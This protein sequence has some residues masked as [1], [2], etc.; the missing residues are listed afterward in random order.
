MMP[1]RSRTQE[2]ATIAGG[3]FWCLQPLFQDLRGVEKVE[4]GYS[5]GHLANPSYEAVC[6]DTTGHAEAVQITFDPQTIPFVDILRPPSRM[7]SPPRRGLREGRVRFGLAWAGHPGDP[8]RNR[9]LTIPSAESDDGRPDP[10]DECRKAR[11]M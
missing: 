11:E 2:S 8:R 3:C 6:T 1:D 10:P 7:V 9:R 4:V 5:G